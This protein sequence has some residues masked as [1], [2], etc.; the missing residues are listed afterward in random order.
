[1]H[2]HHVWKKGAILLLQVILSNINQFSKFWY[3]QG[4]RE[5]NCL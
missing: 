5:E 4:V 1:M 3:A 2:I